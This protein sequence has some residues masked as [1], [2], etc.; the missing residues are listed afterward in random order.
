MSDTENGERCVRCGEVGEDRRTLR[1]AC[2]YAM[3]EM[4]VPFSE[5][6]VVGKVHA[7]IGTKDLWLGDE[8]DLRARGFRPHRVPEYSEEPT[9]NIT[10]SFYNLRVCKDCRGSWMSAI[11][12]WF[13]N[14]EPARRIIGTGIFVRKN[15]ATMEITQEEWDRRYAA[16]KAGKG[17]V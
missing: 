2:F 11:E 13:N 4:N 3:D 6:K 14:V 10:A 7:R 17:E 5:E 15:G 16:S 9:G 1:M 12:D 8:A